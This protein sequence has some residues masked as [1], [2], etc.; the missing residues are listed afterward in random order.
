[1]LNTYQTLKRNKAKCHF[2]WCH[3]G[4]MKF[5]I[6]NM[7]E[8][9]STQE[10]GIMMYRDISQSKHLSLVHIARTHTGRIRMETWGLQKKKKEREREKEDIIRDCRDS[11]LIYLDRKVQRVCSLVRSTLTLTWLS[12]LFWVNRLTPFSYQDSEETHATDMFSMNLVLL[13]CLPLTFFTSFITH[14]SHSTSIFAAI[15]GHHCGQERPV[16][17]LW[18]CA[19]MLELQHGRHFRTTIW[20]ESSLPTGWNRWFH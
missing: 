20:T 7:P 5:L 19:K 14:H 13:G 15:H 12:G 8:T 3:Y 18:I 6:D 11:I 16:V 9:K 4:N 1:M 10:T 2:Y 17:V